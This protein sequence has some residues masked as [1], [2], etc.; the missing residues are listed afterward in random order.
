MVGYVRTI[1][2]RRPYGS[3]YGPYNKYARSRRIVNT[4]A[5]LLR[6]RMGGGPRA[7]LATR[8][9]YGNTYGKRGGELKYIDVDNVPAALPVGGTVD[10]LNAIASGA[11]IDERVG[12][13]ITLKSIFS[14]WGF[15]PSTTTSAPQGTIVRVLIVYDAQ[16]NSA[17][18][19]PAVN[20]ILATGTWDSP[21]NLNN[22]ERFKIITE[23]KVTVGATLYTAGALTAGS[24]VPRVVEKYKKLNMTTTYSGPNNTNANI[25]TGAIYVVT[26]P[27]LNNTVVADYYHRTRYMDC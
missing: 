6:K 1:T 11:G 8:G 21:M 17:A 2:Y 16:A 10:V 4:A 3:V 27:S 23:F 14:R 7:P 26:I 25:A 15:Y 5:K 9:W 19:P 13:Q 24:P 22:R 20:E 12:R 18:S